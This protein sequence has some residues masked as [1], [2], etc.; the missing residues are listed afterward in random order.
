[1]RALL[2]FVASLGLFLVS[3]WF[4]P[5]LQK[6]EI[7]AGTTCTSF[8]HQPLSFDDVGLTHAANFYFYRGPLQPTKYL[9]Y[10]DDCLQSVKVNEV[11][12]YISPK[13]VFC[14]YSKPILF[15][16]SE[17]L[18]SGFNTISVAAT[19]KGGSGGVRLLPYHFDSRVLLGR[20]IFSLAL[21]LIWG[22]CFSSVL[23]RI[24]MSGTT[25]LILGILLRLLY[26]F[27][28]PA[29]FRSNDYH[30]HIEYLNW[31]AKHWSTPSPNGGWEFHQAPLYYFL[32]SATWKIMLWCGSTPLLE[33]GYSQFFALVMSIALLFVI[34]RVAVLLFPRS[35]RIW[36]RLAVVLTASIYPALVMQSARVSND[37]LMTLLSGIFILTLL[38]FC[39]H[40]NRWA[41]V[42]MSTTVGIGVLS[43]QNALVLVATQVGVLALMPKTSMKTKGSWLLISVVNWL[44]ICG[45]Y[46]AKRYWFQSFPGLSGFH[47]EV[48]KALVIPTRL[49]DFVTFNPLRMIELPMFSPW[50]L[51]IRRENFFEAVFRTSL[52]GEF[53]YDP[54][55][56][57][58]AAVMTFLTLYLLGLA[59]VGMLKALRDREIEWLG[60]FMLTVMGICSLIV[61]RL[62]YPYACAQDARYIPMTTIGLIAFAALGSTG[63]STLR[64]IHQFVLLNFFVMVTWWFM[65]LYAIDIVTAASL[66][67]P[68]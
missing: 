39:R 14:D 9:V 34:A 65:R 20:A 32:I 44:L 43:K 63:H 11:F 57:R 42:A 51:D 46:L 28:T 47:F 56:D 64:A 35:D 60:L 22:A 21:I 19:N 27:A 4:S 15:E 49:I 13:K 37:P 29:D 50:V 8:A 41:L 54:N 18:Q 2:G 7:C 33:L 30:G 52:F 67:T 17:K 3:D 55:A 58:L 40:P 26:Y 6:Q 24:G 36:P 59:L 10:A 16:L 5:R 38:E 12:V 53:E 61:F 25:I 66:L 1:M 48:S 31:M 68:T 23:P 45:S 62:G